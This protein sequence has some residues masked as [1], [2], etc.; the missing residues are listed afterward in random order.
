MKRKLLRIT[1]LLVTLAFGWAL[2]YL[3]L[4]HVQRNHSFWVGFISAIAILFFLVLV[5]LIWNK[6]TF[7]VRWIVK[8]EDSGKKSTPIKMYKQIWIMV[9]SFVII[10]GIG[11][12]LLVKKQIRLF[13]E[14]SK[15]QNERIAALSHTTESLRKGN[16]VF[17]LNN[18]LNKVDFELSNSPTRSLSDKTIQRIKELSQSFTPYKY[19]I[20]DSLS[21]N[22]LSP[23]RGRLLL[24]LAYTEMDSASFS[25]IVRNVPF[26]YADL[27]GADLSGIDLSG[28][29]LRY[30]N[31]RD[32]KF[33]NTQFD[34]GDLRNTSFWGS[35]SANASFVGADLRHAIFS[36]S[37]LSNSNFAKSNGNGSL[38]ENA[39]LSNSNFSGA[40]FRWARFIGS[41]MENSDLRNGDFTRT[42]MVRVNLAKADFSNA[43]MKF[44]TLDQAILDPLISDSFEIQKG[45]RTDWITEK[46]IVLD[47]GT[48]S[49]YI[50]ICDSSIVGQHPKYYMVKK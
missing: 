7:L 28:I 20:N 40:S 25:K 18:V 47:E 46:N 43:T 37:D 13:E 11:A 32:G 2:G 6:N 1:I 22:E 33:Q 31:L 19:Y 12:A 3:R 4:P 44:T 15:F 21:N 5:K 42:E 26:T 50:E 35:I 16:Q 29:N 8:T 14:Q 39:T 9:S 45:W 30:A 27:Q 10:G 23:E 17:F 38:L 41:I 36:W 49:K 24:T 34:G 48:L